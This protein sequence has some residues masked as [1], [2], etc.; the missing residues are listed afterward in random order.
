MSETVTQLLTEVPALMLACCDDENFRYDLKAPF[1]YG[2]HLWATNGRILT[3]QPVEDFAPEL[4]D[5]LMQRRG[6]MLIPI[7]DGRPWTEPSGDP[8]ELPQVT[9][10]VCDGCHGQEH[11]ECFSCHGLRFE[12]DEKPIDLGVVSLASHFVALLT[13]HGV[14]EIRVKS[15]KEAVHFAVGASRGC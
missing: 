3:R 6:K 7:G 14:T 4:I 11:V 8:V 1:V 13:D 10:A 15:E 2:D 5:R 9:K 12:I